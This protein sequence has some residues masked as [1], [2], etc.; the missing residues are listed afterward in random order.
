LPYD[1]D[2][3]AFSLSLENDGSVELYFSLGE[4]GGLLSDKFYAD[5]NK[6]ED[7]V[8]V[9]QSKIFRLEI[10]TIAYM[11]CFPECV[12]DGVPKSLLERDENKSARNFTFQLSEKN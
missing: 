8:S 7:E 11:N 10:N 6:K 5:V 2:V 9:L 3:Y 4:N 12:A 1:A